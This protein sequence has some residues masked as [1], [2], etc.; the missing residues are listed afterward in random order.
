MNLLTQ[1]FDRLTWDLD[2]GDP[3]SADLFELR[4]HDHWHANLTVMWDLF[5][6]RPD[7]MRMEVEAELEVMRE[8]LVRLE[9]EELWEFCARLRD[10]LALWS[11][12]C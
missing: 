7:L 12:S 5:E 9:K 8:I 10:R 3:A 6:E 2:P 1:L 11:S 4:L